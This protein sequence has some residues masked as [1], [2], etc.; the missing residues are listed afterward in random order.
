MAAEEL[1]G[2]PGTEGVE[3]DAEQKT[4]PERPVPAGTAEFSADVAEGET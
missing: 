4:A 1:A 3:P 2:F